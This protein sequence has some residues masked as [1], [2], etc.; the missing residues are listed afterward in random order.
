[1]IFFFLFYL[2]VGQGPLTM[3]KYISS[4]LSGANFEYN[5]KELETKRIK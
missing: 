1:M 4:R 3:I 2:E 5:S